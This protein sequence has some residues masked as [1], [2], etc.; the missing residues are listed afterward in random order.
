MKKI[1]FTSLVLLLACAGVR[2]QNIAIRDL[3]VTKN[4]EIV[5]VLF[6]AD[7][8]KRTTRSGETLVFVPVLRGGEY[9]WSLPAIVVEGRRARIAN[10]RHEWVIEAAAVQPAFNDVAVTTGNNSIVDYSTSIDWQPWMDGANLDTELLRMECC[11]Y[12]IMEGT[13]LAENLYLPAPVVIKPEPVIEPLPEPQPEPEPVLTTGEKLAQEHPFIVPYSNFERLEPGQ[14]FDEDR[15]N[16]LIVYFNLS[17]YVVDPTYKTNAE[18]LG[19]MI[20]SIKALQNSSDSRVRT[21]VIAGFSSPEGSFSQ[22]DRLAFDRATAVKN[23]LMKETK[24]PDEAVM[25]YNGS[26]DWRGLKILVE[27][28]D[29]PSKEEVIRIIDTVP[30]WNPGST[31]GREKLLME[32]DGG[33]P[34]QYML[35]NF[36]PLLRNAAY[37]KIYYDDKNSML[38]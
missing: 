23:H 24:L 4:G 36:F 15:E 5:T 9:E 14:L 27:Q 31:P 7:I 13:T 32:L 3:Q 30:V 22:N 16:S 29:M 33:V 25:I 17:R 38:P 12:D 1:I 26:E 11:C 21:V 37:I 35:K 6:R 19:K 10:Q 20:S 34:Y 18:Q 8:P 2:A 28:S